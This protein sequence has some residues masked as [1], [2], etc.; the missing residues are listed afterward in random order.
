[1]SVT[2]GQVHRV[3]DLDLPALDVYRHLKDKHLA[4]RQGLFVAEGLEVVRRLLRSRFKV[5]SLLLT[6]GKL[7]RLRADLRP[8]VPVYVAS[9]E[10]ME[11]IAGFAIHRGAVACGIRQA[12]LSLDQAV[13]A[14]GD[15]RLV[16]VLENIC[17]AQNVGVIIR[18]A[19]AFGAD[20]VVLAG[21]CDP[22]YRRAIRVSMGNVFSTPLYHSDRLAEDL[23]V[24]KQRLA[25][26]VVAAELSARAT[27]LVEAPRPGRVALVFGAEGDGL[28][29]AVLNTCDQRVVIPMKPGSDSV[30][31]GVASGVFLYAYSASSP[32]DST[33]ASPS[34]N[35][36]A[37]AGA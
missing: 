14:A 11:A 3:D 28:S 9:V 23:R 1:M 17:D 4:C 7:E 19:A 8:D 15:G 13:A 31:V 12:K 10:Q 33:A 27:S 34:A 18:N 29:Q 24:L 32:T 16:V 36:E 5:Q 20:L 35:G 21:C 25:V 2:S 37:A 26:E 22:F 6:P 30:N